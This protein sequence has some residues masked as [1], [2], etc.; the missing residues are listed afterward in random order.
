MQRMG[1][2]MIERYIRHVEQG[3]DI[4]I[5]VRDRKVMPEGMTAPYWF[6][7]RAR[8]VSATGEKP[9]A[10][11]WELERPMPEALFEG[12]RTIAAT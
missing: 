1:T 11:T 12:A 3:S 5:F 10:F 2:P 7:G 8:Y 4:T 6:L 9:V